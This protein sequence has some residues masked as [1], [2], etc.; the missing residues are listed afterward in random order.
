MPVRGAEAVRKSLSSIRKAGVEATFN[1]LEVIAVGVLA[2]SDALAPE[3]TGELRLSGE[4]VT[5]KRGTGR[6]V[7]VVYGRSGPSKDY[8]LVQ[9]EGFFNP[10]PITR[11]KPGAGRKYLSRAYAE[12]VPKLL[13]EMG[14]GVKASIAKAAKRRAL[15]RR[16]R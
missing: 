2:R 14:L 11:T 5:T 4:V 9:H 10:G 8:A 7:A 13:R 3:L 1:E 12:Q 15:S 16:G 6:E